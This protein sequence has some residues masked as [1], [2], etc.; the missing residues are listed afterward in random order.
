LGYVSN[1]FTNPTNKALTNTL[2]PGY[3]VGIDFVTYYDVVFRIEYGRNKQN[4][5][6]FYFYLLSDI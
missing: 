4:N 2:L 6:G 5:G 3:G 1:N